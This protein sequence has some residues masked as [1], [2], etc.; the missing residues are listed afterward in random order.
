MDHLWNDGLAGI[1]QN[2]S[3]VLFKHYK[4]LNQ[5]LNKNWIVRMNH[6][7]SK[8]GNLS[9]DPLTVYSWGTFLCNYHISI[10]FV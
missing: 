5:K 9:Y 2:D 6:C 3:S 8:N 10:V 1:E 4:L 7:A